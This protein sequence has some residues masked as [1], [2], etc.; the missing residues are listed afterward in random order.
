MVIK[1]TLAPTVLLTPSVTSIVCMNLQTILLP[2]LFLVSYLS[3]FHAVGN[4]AIPNKL[5]H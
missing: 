2:I 5:N 4:M 1:L 3:S